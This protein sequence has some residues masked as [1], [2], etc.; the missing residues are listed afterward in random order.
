MFD[1]SQFTASSPLPHFSAG[2]NPRPRAASATVLVALSSPLMATGLTAIL[3]RLEGCEVRVW[4]ASEAWVSP[5]TVVIV[6]DLA[7]A[8]QFCTG[9][10]AAA[11][12]TTR[13]P[14]T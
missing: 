8:A 9:T 10:A 12:T 4:G 6:D 14:V 13:L 2:V 7:L 5:A 11:E 1:G 3:R